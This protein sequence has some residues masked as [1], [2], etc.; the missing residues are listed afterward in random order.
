MRA[1]LGRAPSAA[2]L[3][4]AALLVAITG[5]AAGYGLEFTW[6]GDTVQ[7]VAPSEVAE[8]HFTLTNT[9]ATADVF[10]FGC[11][12]ALAVPGWAVVY[13]VRGV[14]VEPG[15]MIYDT[16]EAGGTDTTAKVTVYTNATEGEEVVFLH[17]RSTGDTTLAESVATHTIV[18]A[19]IEEGVHLGAPAAGL[20]VVP[21]P[22][23]RQTGALV[24]FSTSER[25]SFGFALHDAT[26]RL[27][28]TVACSAVHAGRQCVRW[29][30]ERDLPG[31][32]YLLR[33]S[34]GAESAVA[35]LIVE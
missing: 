20:R 27:V 21:N 34:A 26:G 24:M 18:G 17:V 28:Q 23:C 29:Q 22:V 14:C 13:C 30:P 11:S 6:R 35:T 19:A 32:V 15:A 1:R 5:R 3:M 8:F 25:T 10:R 4:V 2:G 7:H 33:L 12:V 16:L 31:G 9:G